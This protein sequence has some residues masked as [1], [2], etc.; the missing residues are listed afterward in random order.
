MEEVEVRRGIL[1]AGLS[2]VRFY[3]HYIL[4]FIESHHFKSAREKIIFSIIS[5]FI[6]RYERVP[7]PGELKVEISAFFSSKQAEK[8]DDF[9]DLKEMLLFTKDLYKESVKSPV[10]PEWLA[11]NLIPYIR[12]RESKFLVNSMAEKLEYNEQLDLSEVISKLERLNTLGTSL[13]EE[14][15]EITDDLDIIT[16]EDDRDPIPTPWPT[17][18]ARENTD[19]GIGRG[20]YGMIF[21]YTNVAK[22]TVLASIAM[23]AALRKKNI[24]FC[25]IEDNK[26]QVYKRLLA[27]ATNTPRS[28]CNGN[29]KALSAI[30]KYKKLRERKVIGDIYV[31]KMYEYETKVSEL[32]PLLRSLER[33]NKVKFD[34]II[35]DGL[36]LMKPEAVKEDG[37]SQGGWA[38]IEDMHRTFHKVVGK[39][40][41]RGWTTHQ[42][43][44]ADKRENI[45]HINHLGKAK[46]VGQVPELAVSLN[47]TGEKDEETGTE[48]MVLFGARNRLGNKDWTVRIKANKNLAKFEEV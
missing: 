5:G 15:P 29:A 42:A 11:N 13:M 12:N 41:I 39:L 47:E 14:V 45:L 35:V 16:T 9:V 37:D 21:A 6:K 19:G 3:E 32:I 26:K 20:E 17:V 38:E 31:H 30:E 8:F 23:T 43:R 7:S 44:D 46:G 28:L 1:I 34:M 10:D 33:K 27:C 18:N 40:N 48:M 24:L 25:T 4:P 2:D 22:S 36:Q